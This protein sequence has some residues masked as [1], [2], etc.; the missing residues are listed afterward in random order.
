VFRLL[1]GF[2]GGGRCGVLFFYFLVY[3]WGVGGGGGGGGV[4]LASELLKPCDRDDK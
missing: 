3:L 4:H 1:R 2:F